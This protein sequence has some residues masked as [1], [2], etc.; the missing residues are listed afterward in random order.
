MTADNIQLDINLEETGWDEELPGAG[1]LVQ[2][3][4]QKV[5]AGTAEGKVL[6]EFPHLEL[7]ILLTGDKSI[8]VLNREYRGKDKAT[9]VLSFPALSD[10][11]IEDYF[12]RGA[13]LPDYPVS[14]GDIILA[15]ETVKSEAISSGKSLENH[16][17]HLVVH[18]ILHLLGYDHQND[19]DA[20]EMEGL[21]KAILG[22]L[23]IDDPYDEMST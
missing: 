22:T 5:V 18:G 8:Q 6:A 19:A 1:D 14:L 9:N 12:H 3:C 23:G 16:F 17:C 10:E 13:I 7:S 2:R 15:L 21:E 11:E 20:E 4:L